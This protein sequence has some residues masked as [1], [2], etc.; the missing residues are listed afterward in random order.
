M[1]AEVEDR[2]GHLP[3]TIRGGHPL[4]Q[5]EVEVS[6]RVSSQFAT[7][8]L[9]IAPLLGGLS[10][11]I[12]GGLASRPPLATTLAV[13]TEAGITP[14]ADWDQ[15]VGFCW[16]LPGWDLPGPRRLSGC[17]GVTSCCGLGPSTLLPLIRRTGKGRR[18]LFPISS[19]WAWP[20]KEKE[21]KLGSGR[22]VPDQDFNGEE[23]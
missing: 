19:R 10:L 18:R 11:R 4:R 17:F 3:I 7:A 21:M 2:D 14:Q 5:R 20:W 1:G 8:L 15:L 9:F 13:M 16:R 22:D 23:D 12:T 6:G